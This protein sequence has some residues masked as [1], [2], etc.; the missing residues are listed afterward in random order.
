MHRRTFLRSAGLVAVDLARRPELW[1]EDRQ[2]PKNIGDVLATVVK[3][4]KLPGMAATAVRDGQV[5]ARGVAGVRE[6]GKPDPIE[7]ED[8][9]AI[10]SCTKRM[11]VLLVMRLVDAGKLKFDTTV[12]DALPDVKMRDE[13]R[14]VTLAQ[15]LTFTGGI[16][17]YTQIGPRRTPILFEKG[18]T[19]ERLAHFVEHLLNEEP[20]NAVRIEQYSNASYILAGFMAARLCKAP[21]ESL[22]S[23]YVFR[24]LGMTKSGF[25][26]PRNAQRPTEP[27]QHTR[28]STGYKPVPAT[29]PLPE[30]IMAAPGGAHCSIGD[31]ARFAA[32]MLAASQGQYTSLKPATVEQ[33][34][35]MLGREALGGGGEDFGGTQWL[36]AGLQVLPRKKLAIVVAVNGGDAEDACHAAFEAIGKNV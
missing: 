22:M 5:V 17:P 18:P 16:Q 19:A 26:R 30:A 13:Y 23:E 36:H 28:G 34:K 12:G 3:D 7:L 35:K 1:A 25:G 8:R 29:E 6:V 31:F 33:A 11:T 10:G 15:L 32:Y 24:P 2:E 20:I 9:F 27:W 21:F 4:H 14:K